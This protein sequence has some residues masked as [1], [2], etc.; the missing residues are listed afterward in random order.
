MGAMGAIGL[1]GKGLWE[2]SERPAFTFARPLPKMGIGLRHGT[3][4]AIAAER[5]GESQ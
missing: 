5:G 2:A 1:R 3:L 4:K